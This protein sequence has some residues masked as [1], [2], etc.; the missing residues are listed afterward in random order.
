MG[1]VDGMSGG[2][3]KTHQ[4]DGRPM[5]VPE[6]AQMLGLTPAALQLRRSRLNGA[7]YQVIVDMYR[8][9]QFGSYHD[10][11]PRWMVEGR[12]MTLQDI[13]D[14]LGI[15][16]HSLI[17]YRVKHPGASIAEAIEYYRT[18]RSRKGVGGRKATVYRVRGKDYTIPQ[19]ARRFGV[20]PQSVRRYVDHH[21]M[22]E[23]LE[24]YRARQ[25]TREARAHRE[26]MRILGY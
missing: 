2:K 8:A 20:D 1:G 18:P 25:S 5:T 9:N 21:S 26:I 19:V 13:A 14:M 22:A 12:W 6:I 7:S 15:A 11:A 23:A 17:N 3:F 16:K 10:R 24:H 4:I